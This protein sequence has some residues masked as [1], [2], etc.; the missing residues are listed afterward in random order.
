MYAD[1]NVEVFCPRFFARGQGLG[2]KLYVDSPQTT[3]HHSFAS[4]SLSR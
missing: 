2:Y 3:K 1:S 4:N